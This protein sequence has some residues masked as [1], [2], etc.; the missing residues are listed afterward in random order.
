MKGECALTVEDIQETYCKENGYTILS[1]ALAH[2]LGNDEAIVYTKLVGFQLYFKKENKL[3]EGYFFCSVEFLEFRCNVSQY[4]Q[5]KI[6][7]D[8]IGRG[9]IDIKYSGMP[10][11]RYIKVLTNESAILRVFKPVEVEEKEKV[12]IPEKLKEKYSQPFDI[13]VLDNQIKKAA[14]SLGVGEN[15]AKEVQG[16]YR[17]YIDYFGEPYSYYSNNSVSNLVS[18]VNDLDLSYNIFEENT[19]QCLLE[20]YSETN[21][22]GKGYTRSINN[23]LTDEMLDILSYRIM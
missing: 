19:F 3:T 9:L 8:L 10:R 4:Q 17:Q 18:R 6:M 11:R 22:E 15:T 1:D 14:A 21:V 12:P 7:A 23:M 16:L 2:N 13:S 20:A 5:K